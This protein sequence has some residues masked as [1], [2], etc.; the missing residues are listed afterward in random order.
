MLTWLAPSTLP[1]EQVKTKGGK[2]AAD[3]EPEAGAEEEVPW[4]ERP[5]PTLTLALTL[6]L[7]LALALAPALALALVLALALAL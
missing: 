2:K 1:P 5:N 6:A 3:D 4:L 7:A